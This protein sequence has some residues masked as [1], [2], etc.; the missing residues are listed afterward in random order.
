MMSSGWGSLEA[1]SVAG[2]EGTGETTEI[3]TD[4]N[5]ELSTKASGLESLKAMSLREQDETTKASEDIGAEAG[6][7]AAVDTGMY[8]LSLSQKNLLFQG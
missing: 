8:F 6:D 3:S 1:K 2:G 7:E 4:K 5:E